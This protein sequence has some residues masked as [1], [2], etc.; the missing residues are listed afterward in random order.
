MEM[1]DK[2]ET[3]NIHFLFLQGTKQGLSNLLA[4][5]H[6]TYY[7]IYLLLFESYEYTHTHTLD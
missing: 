3:R 2:H 4:D 7:K 6:M 5:G 1:H